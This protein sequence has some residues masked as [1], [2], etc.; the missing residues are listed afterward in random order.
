MPRY[1]LTA[2]LRIRALSQAK[3]GRK[4]DIRVDVNEQ[5]GRREG[6]SGLGG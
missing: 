3:E 1:S 6:K 2:E 5:S 4:K